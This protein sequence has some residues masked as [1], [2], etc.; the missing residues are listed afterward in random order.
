[1]NRGPGALL[2]HGDNASVAGLKGQ[3]H[4]VVVVTG[5]G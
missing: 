1:M 5:V 3:W 2:P 4:T